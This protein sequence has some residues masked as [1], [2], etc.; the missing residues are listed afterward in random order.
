MDVVLVLHDHEA[1]AVRAATIRSGTSNHARQAAAAA[2]QA[3]TG[4][5]GTIGSTERDTIPVEHDAHGV[6]ATAGV[7]AGCAAVSDSSANHNRVSEAGRRAGCIPVGE[8]RIASHRAAEHRTCED[9]TCEHPTCER[10]RTCEDPTCEHRSAEYCA[11][12]AACD[13]SAARGTLRSGDEPS[14]DAARQERTAAGSTV[15]TNCHHIGHDA[16]STNTGGGTAEYD[17]ALVR[18]ERRFDGSWLG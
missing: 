11:P 4:S 17:D 6:G 15:G 3:R 14:R 2:P 8:R 7:G 1:G 9:R 12:G 5:G 18:R 13:R 10:R 16:R